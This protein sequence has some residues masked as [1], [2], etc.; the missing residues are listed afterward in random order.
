MSLK[1]KAAL[2][3][4]STKPGSLQKA[5]NARASPPPLRT[6]QL[7][8]GIKAGQP[9]APAA[10]KPHDEDARAPLLPGQVV[11]IEADRCVACQ[12]SFPS[13]SQQN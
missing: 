12:C 6:T 7:H 1:A 13:A 11:H 5:G 4:P 3:T 8:K 10:T 2:Q 9:F